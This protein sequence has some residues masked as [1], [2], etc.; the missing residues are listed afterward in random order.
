MEDILNQ[1]LAINTR[2]FAPS[3]WW[4]HVPIAHWITLAMQ[5]EKIVELGTHYGVSF[6]AF[7]EA[8]EAHSVNTFT[9][10]IDTW[11]GDEQAGF[12]SDEIFTHVLEHWEKHH[13][14]RSALIRSTFEEASHKFPNQSLDLVHIDGLH[15]YEA[16][17]S[18]FES[19]YPKLKPEG[20]ILFHDIN[21]R[22]GDF[23]VWKLW[24]EIKQEH[25]T[26]EI[27]NGHGLG[28]LIQGESVKEKLVQLP[29]I[30]NVLRA[31]GVLLENY[32]KVLMSNQL[33]QSELK[34][35]EAEAIRLNKDLENMMG[36]L[37]GAEAK[38]SFRYQLFKKIGLDTTKL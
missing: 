8:A 16:V 24:E 7:C 25:Q 3:A 31:K 28:I 33:L 37:K 4:Q 29:S 14:A 10:A 30:A 23:G 32:S 38:A 19:W 35:N 34:A 12:Y 2:Y 5:P 22:H 17:K 36:H 20:V 15:T 27:D 6:F 21:V 13:K 1:S 26:Y 18:D 9:Y 11:K